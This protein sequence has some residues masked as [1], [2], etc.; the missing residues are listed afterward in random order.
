M[1]S[2]FYQQAYGV[3]IELKNFYPM[4]GVMAGP[5]VSEEEVLKAN[6]ILVEY[7]SQ[8]V[9]I[10]ADPGFQLDG[11]TFNVI[12]TSEIVGWDIGSY[13]SDGWFEEV[14]YKGAFDPS[15]N[16]AQGWTLFSKYMN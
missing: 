15:S 14:Y 6:A 16:W 11:L 7:F 13:P 3:D 12:P 4:L 1:N 9:N 5:D 8:N 10:I 2:I